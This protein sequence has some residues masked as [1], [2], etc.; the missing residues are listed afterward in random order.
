[1]Y[2]DRADKRAKLLLNNVAIELQRRGKEASGLRQRKADEAEGSY[3]GPSREATVPD[4]KAA[5]AVDA[6]DAPEKNSATEKV[7]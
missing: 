6:P 1:M 7:G 5:D 2:E 4:E 3:C